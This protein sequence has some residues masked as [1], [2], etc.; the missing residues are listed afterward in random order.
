MLT[1][2]CSLA[3]RV[4]YSRIGPAVFYGSSAANYRVD[5]NTGHTGVHDGDS[6]SGAFCH[7]C[8]GD[9]GNFTGVVAD[10]L[11]VYPPIRRVIHSSS[12]F[13]RF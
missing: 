2:A 10:A 5:L 8:F 7:R 1:G 12:Y 4:G 6:F 9:A 11:V 13:G 3:D